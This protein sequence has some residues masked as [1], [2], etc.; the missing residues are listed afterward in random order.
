MVDRNLKA[1]SHLL[2]APHSL[3][4]HIRIEMA[5]ALKL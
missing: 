5:V 4:V 1:G 3:F 2:L